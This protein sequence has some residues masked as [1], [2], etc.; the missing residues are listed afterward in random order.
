M[1]IINMQDITEREVAWLWH[2]YLPRGKVTLVQG[3]PG[4][5][6]T[7]FVLA[8]AA[9][10]TRGVTEGLAEACAEEN[11]NESFIHFL[12]W[13]SYAIQLEFP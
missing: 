11:R 9:L 8:V 2:P 1:K 10:L 12:E 3:D 7:T 13:T 6:K 4:D 5:G